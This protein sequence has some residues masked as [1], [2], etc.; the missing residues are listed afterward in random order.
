MRAEGYKKMMSGNYTSIDNQGVS[1]SMPAVT[2]PDPRHVAINLS[3]SNL[4]TFPPSGD[5]RP[6]RDAVDTSSKPVSASDEP[7]QSEELSIKKC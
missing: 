4:Q 2:D 3:D 1:G 7:Q 6:P 5:A